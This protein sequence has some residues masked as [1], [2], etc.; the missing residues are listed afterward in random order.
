MSSQEAAANRPP[1]NMMGYLPIPKVLMKV[2]L[3]MM[4]SM[5]VLSLYNVIDSIFVGMIS[6]NALAAVSL[7]FPMQMKA[8]MWAVPSRLAPLTI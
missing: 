8:S 5:T 6:E 3:P 7:A 2:S 4:I 1:E